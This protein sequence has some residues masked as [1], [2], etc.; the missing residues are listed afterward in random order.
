MFKGITNGTIKLH[1]ENLASDCDV[2][3]PEYYVDDDNVMV[4]QRTIVGA[5][6]PRYGGAVTTRTLHEHLG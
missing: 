2:L 6:N 3:V 5:P 1:I 4:A